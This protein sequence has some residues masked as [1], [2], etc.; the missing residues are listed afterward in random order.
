MNEELAKQILKVFANNPFDAF[1]HKQISSRIGAGSKAERQEVIRTIQQLA[2]EKHLVEDD[3]KGK[4]KINPKSINGD[5]LPRNYVTGI[6]DMKQGGKAY[7]I[8]EEEGRED[9]QIAP[10][11]THHALHGDTVRVL[12]FPQRKMHKPEGQVVEILKRAK[13]RFVGV[14]QR[15]ERFAFMVSDSRTMQVDIFIHIDD[16]GGAE[17]G[18]KVL[19]EMTDW[20]ERMNNPVGKVIKRL[21]R[22][23]DNNVE[24]QS[25]L[26]EYDFP[27]DFP[28]E[29]EEEA[30]KIRK[31]TK[32]EIANRRD[33]RDVTTFT[34]DPADAKDFDDALSFRELPNGHVEVGVHIADVSYYVKPGSAIDREAYERGTSVYLVDRTIPMLPEK[35]CNEVCSLRQDEDKLCFSVVMEMD[36]KGERDRK[37]ANATP[38]VLKTWMGKT[39]IRSD[40]RMAYEEAQEII[41]ANTVPDGSPVG[42]AILR[43]HALATV[44]RSQ[45]YK[46]GAINFES[47]EVKFQLDENAKPIGVYIKE[48]KEANWLIEEFMLLANKS[49]AEW[50]GKNQNTQSNPK[51]QNTRPFVY[52]VHDEPNPEKLNTFVEFVTKLGFSMKTSS[53]K[54]LAE[55]Y[56]RLFEN[57][58]GRGEEHM[59]DTI[60]IRTMSKAYYSTEN[61]GHYGLAFP[62]YTHFTSPIRRYPDLMV[63]RLLEH[64][65]NS[66]PRIPN[67]ELLE[68]YCRHCSVMEKKAADAERTSVKYKQAEYLADKLGQVFPALISGVSKWGIYA[69]IEDSKCEGMIPIGSLKDDY[70]MLDED[71]YQVIGRRHGRCYKLGYPVHIRV[72]K[73]DL[74]KKQIDFDLV[75]E[76]ELTPSRKAKASNEKRP[77]GKTRE[78]NKSQKK[79]KKR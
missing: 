44:L 15:Q 68:E 79:R 2:E 48:S 31:P 63:H 59:V 1:N 23:G 41:E 43:L 25:I 36:A 57:I 39:V 60:A 70:Y 3:H 50:V 35:L 66:E 30:K 16:L 26:A 62:Y 12:M 75:E 72:R 20:P 54:A 37:G 10:N 6:I 67:S 64:Y 27:L 53:R 19:V 71:N 32:K 61:I 7:V 46:D 11:N 56:N 28:K 55:S 51:T 77:S 18:E 13:T 29:V 24:M 74:I 45:R 22:P 9:I 42:E 4:Y 21:G 8:P 14:I 69:E 40:R 47:Q 73:V 58:A 5:L 76:E 52:R 34:I 65:L 33:F 49:V 78:S 38:K 17:N